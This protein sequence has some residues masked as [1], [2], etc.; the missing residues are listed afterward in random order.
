MKYKHLNL[1]Y[2]TLVSAHNEDEGSRWMI[3]FRRII[4]C[5]KE[6]ETFAYHQG[7][8]AGK[9]SLQPRTSHLLQTLHE[10]NTAIEELRG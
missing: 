2:N 1:V 8:I 4:D 5:V 3:E 9:E 10:L 6:D 7:Y